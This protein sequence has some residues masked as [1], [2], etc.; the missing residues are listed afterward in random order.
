MARRAAGARAV[1]A[2]SPENAVEG[3]SGDDEVLPVLE[4]L[5]EVLEVHPRVGRPRQAHEA[6]PEGVGHARGRRS[7]LI[8][9]HERGGTPLAVGSAEALRLPNGSS[10]EG[11]GICHLECSALEGVENHETLCGLLRQGQHTSR[12]RLGRGVTFSLNA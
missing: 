10:Q 11:G 8:A 6:L 7:A 3:G 4:E 2:S 5:T 12:L 1:D 9:M